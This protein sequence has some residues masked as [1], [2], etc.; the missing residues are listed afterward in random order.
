MTT[1]PNFMCLFAFSSHDKL[2]FGKLVL[3][4]RL[5]CVDLVTTAGIHVRKLLV[6]NRTSQESRQLSYKTVCFPSPSLEK[7]GR[8]KQ[9]K[10]AKETLIN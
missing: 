9:S 7:D 6:T 5:E 10:V 4:K 3:A 2:K 1:E 8:L